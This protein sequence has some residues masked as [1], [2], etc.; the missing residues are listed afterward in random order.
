TYTAQ[1]AAG[2]LGLPVTR[3]VNVVLDP[4]GDEDGDGLTNAQELAQGTNPYQGDTDGDGFDDKA[5][6]LAGT[7]PNNPASLPDIQ[8]PLI[9]LI[10]SNPLDVYKGS[11]FS[12]PG[13]TVTDNVDVT[14]TITG[15]GAVNTVSVG[16][17]T[18]T[19]TVQ[20]AAG[21]Q[22][23]PVM[24]EVRVVLDPAGDEDGDGLTNAQELALGTDPYQKDS[25]HDGVNDSV[26]IADGTSPNDANS[27]NMLNKGLVAYYPFNGNANDESGNGNHGTTEGVTSETDRF[28]N[29]G[30][31]FL[32]SGVFSPESHIKIPT[33]SFNIT[34]ERTFSAW[35]R[36]NGGQ[37]HPRIFS[38]SGWEVGINPDGANPRIFLN[39]GASS[40][41]DTL[42]SSEVPILGKFVQIVAVFSEAGMSAYVNGTLVGYKPWDSASVSDFSRGFVPE[43]GG[44]SGALSDA[45]GG[46][47]DDIRIYN[48]ALSATEVGQLYV[49]ESPDGTNLLV[50][51][52]FENSPIR[53]QQITTLDPQIDAWSSSPNAHMTT[54]YEAENS[55]PQQGNRQAVFNNGEQI[56]SASIHQDVRLSPGSWYRLSYWTCLV[57]LN[58]D[59]VSGNSA[60]KASIIQGGVETSQFT[61]AP[62]PSGTWIQKTIIFQA[63]TPQVTVRFEDVSTATVS[64]DVALDS[65]E[66][67]KI[68]ADDPN[69]TDGD[70]LTDAW[71]IGNGRYQIVSGSFTWDQAKADALS[72]GG[73]L[74][75]ITSSGEQAFIE[76]YLNLPV[77]LN[78]QTWIWIGAT[79][80]I[81]EGNWKWVTGESW[82]YSHWAPNEPSNGWGGIEHYLVMS[83]YWN[84]V[85]DTIPGYQ[86]GYILEFGYPSDPTKLDTDGD[87][88]DDRA[89]S[90][91]GTDPNNSDREPPLITLIGANP[92]E[93]YKGATFTDPG[94]TVTDNV[95]ES[96]TISGN[97]AVD[98]GTVGIYTLT[99]T[100]QDMTGN[101]GLPVTR[102]VNVVL[103]P[104]ADEDGDGISNGVEL[105]RSMNPYNRDTDGDGY[106]DGLEVYRGSEPTVSANTPLSNLLIGTNVVT[107][108]SS[109]T[110]IIQYSNKPQVL[111]NVIAV[112]AGSTNY[113][114]LQLDRRVVQWR[115]NSVTNEA[116]TYATNMV[117]IAASSTH[118]AGLT[119]DGKVKVWGSVVPAITNVPADLNNAVAIQAGTSFTLVLLSDGRIQ[120]W[121]SSSAVTTCPTNSL[122]NVVKISAGASGAGA[123]TADGR[124]VFWGNMIGIS[125]SNFTGAYDF[126]VGSS[127]TVGC[128]SNQVPYAVST[129][130][131][132]M[133]NFAGS[134]N[135]KASAAGSSYYYFVRSNNSLG[136]YYNGTMMTLPTAIQSSTN[137][138]AV[139]IKSSAVIALQ[140]QIRYEAPYFNLGSGNLSGQVGLP[141]SLSLTATGTAPIVYG[142]R[143]LP[144]GLSL[145]SQSGVI[146]GNPNAAGSYSVVFSASNVAG[147]M[148][149]TNPFAISK[150]DQTIPLDPTATRDL[151]DGSFTLSATSSSGLP[152]TYTSSDTSVATVSGTMVTPK[153]VGETRITAIQDGDTN[154]NP[155]MS[156]TQNLTIT[157]K[158]TD[159]D[160]LT[161]ACERGYGRYYL[162]PTTLGWNEAKAD[163]EARG[164]HLA[165]IT[166][167]GEWQTILSLFGA[168]FFASKQQTWLGG[169]YSQGQWTWLT[170]EAWSYSRWRGGEPNYGYTGCLEVTSDQGLWND[171]APIDPGY[172]ITDRGAYL[173]EYGYPTDPA[174]ADTDGDGFDDKVESLAGIDPNNNSARPIPPKIG[175]GMG[176]RF[177]VETGYDW[178]GQPDTGFAVVR[179]VGSSSF[180]GRICL[181]GTLADGR[182]LAS[183]FAGW[184]L[185][186]GINYSFGPG[187]GIAFRPGP[188]SSNFG[189]YNK[190]SGQADNGIEISMEGFVDGEA[191]SLSVYDKDIHSGSPRTNRFGV[192][193]D[194]YVLQG[195]EPYGRDNGD[196][197]EVTQAH[198]FYYF[199][200]SPI[201]DLKDQ[202]FVEGGSLRLSLSASG[203]EPLNYEWY[204]GGE[205]VMGV[206]GPE[207]VREV[208]NSSDAGA[209]YVVVRN[210]YGSA[211]SRTVQ[212][213]MLSGYE[214]WA[215][216]TFGLNGTGAM[217][218][219]DPDNDGLNN[220]RE[221]LLGTSPIAKDTDGDGVND[222]VE[223]EDGTNPNNSNDFGGLSLGLVGYY[224]L[225][226]NASDASGNGAHGVITGAEP[227]SN[228]RKET[229]NAL[230]FDG[231]GQKVLFPYRASSYDLSNRDFCYAIWIR[232]DEVDGFERI[233][234]GDSEG[235]RRFWFE[236]T[237]G[238]LFVYS[239]DPYGNQIGWETGVSVGVRK[240]SHLVMNRSNGVLRVYVDGEK[241]AERDYSH[242][243]RTTS[244]AFAIGNNLGI[245]PFFKGSL[246][247]FR[248]YNRALAEGEITALFK[249]EMGPNP[250]ISLLGA[251][252]IE[253]YKG[254]PFIDPG[255]TV[256]DDKD[257]GLSIVVSGTVN[258]G[259]VG[260]YTLTYS[261]TDSDGNE[262]TPVTR[263]VNVV[264]DPNADEDG[265]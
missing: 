168:E 257:S 44:N 133:Y 205:R 170:G 143:N 101:L 106:F 150:G 7:D 197:Y 32:F 73:H 264:L 113:L 140:G 188:D 124:H 112:A 244:D 218:E 34:T 17:Y 117:A 187:A 43:V 126:A 90:L 186:S 240:W 37:Q 263:T 107:W 82:N 158:D 191:V 11:V 84:D 62:S 27:F 88:Y 171:T 100:T 139:N 3:T 233:G 24:R 196:D 220:A 147:V 141:F 207:L 35:V 127:Y 183:A 241:A 48:R 109:T 254:T 180:T 189:G 159:G 65:V 178:G 223:V 204:R 68:R 260:S 152:V 130:N 78:G 206:S 28:G 144:S 145:N 151:V 1:D 248:I 149:R 157:A 249:R 221:Y 160:G 174:K 247:D 103:D 92:L 54:G 229:S 60:L 246:S 169:Q 136:G 236:S 26:E 251:N 77:A 245:G 167:E 252:P 105:A 258:R 201:G 94:A 111:Q 242:T 208:G 41:V 89:E 53:N 230:H 39:K 231:N 195:G 46:I 76:N 58:A 38:T 71:E 64:K 200:G 2:N 22:G 70:G 66:L 121:G 255:A 222:S 134:I 173:L 115:T 40:E 192:T 83:D 237:S 198:G 199:E 50:N 81:Q 69:D 9:T 49:S 96:R 45:F 23:L 12:D 25:D 63:N 184:P 116:P 67:I 97:G 210:A 42:Y 238:Y 8:A 118:Q 190:V 261:A 123:R 262:G 93:I 219:A 209:Y 85:S 175:Y 203:T 52:G 165:T 250:V 131:I 30:K 122:S 51:G 146:S 102:T 95:D 61:F 56:P 226:G 202:K 234:G 225:H 132:K 110:Q 20:D 80:R 164:G 163:A 212:V 166:T 98:T 19:Y 185:D 235:G 153:S 87:G 216:I 14:R 16:I 148:Y 129:A 74:A 128:V 75:T 265:W 86:Y 259:A 104:A 156:V 99:Y 232:H 108:L 120:T 114:A 177:E 181:K 155:A 79:D 29:S 47:I 256:V 33:Q 193:T 137:I 142:A 119:A 13:A 138:Q 215:Q 6:S 227:S 91:T 228:Q 36:Y 135:S 243:I 239:F 179:N 125:P 21:N 72:R 10:G 172:Q 253:I 213:S 161:D 55:N 176:Y 4:A 15:S 162:V 217:E 57:G 194:A 5:E 18:L 31:A 211:T 224:P 214:W 154:W 59:S 182:E